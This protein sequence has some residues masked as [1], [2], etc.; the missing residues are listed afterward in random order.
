MLC[1]HLK[2][3]SDYVKE[4]HIEIGSLDLIK[5]VCKKCQIT[6]ECPYIPIENYDEHGRKDSEN[7]E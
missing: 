2:G 1:E 6:T 3:L 4:N 5:V 7:K